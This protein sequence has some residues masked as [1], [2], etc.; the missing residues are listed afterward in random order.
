[1]TKVIG[2]VENNHITGVVYGTVE[3]PDDVS[4]HKQK[5]K[6]IVAKATKAR[7]K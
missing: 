5:Y 3:I 1:M 2:I 7:M 4:T 6:Q